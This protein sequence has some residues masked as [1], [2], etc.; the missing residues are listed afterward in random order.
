[1]ADLSKQQRKDY[2]KTLYL[3]ERL[4]QEEIAERVGVTRATINRWINAESWE[5]LRTSLTI[6]KEEQI[7]N[8]YQQIKNLNDT[9]LSREEGKRFATA[10]EADTLAK[11]AAIVNKLETDVGLAD[12]VTVFRKFTAFLRLNVPEELKRVTPILD[13]YVKTHLNG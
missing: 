12:V 3:G 7:K 4:T 10:S 13:L 11:Y 2:A 5:Q 9:I 8:V 1:M 6:T